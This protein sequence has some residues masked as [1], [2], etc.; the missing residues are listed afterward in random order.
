M[1][2]GRIGE[3]TG[4]AMH[5]KL[6]CPPANVLA[7]LVQ[8]Q[9]VDPQ[10]SELTAHLE[11]CSACQAQVST[12]PP[13]NPLIESLRG[14]APVEDQIARAAPLDRK[15]QADSAAT[16]KRRARRARGHSGRFAR[17]A[18]GRRS[19]SDSTFSR[20][21]NKPDELGRLG[22]YRI[23]KVLGQGGMG[24][25]ADR[26]RGR[27]HQIWTMQLEHSRSLTGSGRS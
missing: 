21:R 27:F 7:E 17:H 23:L 4:I 3:W 20:R 13:S 6:K 1:R 16:F 10:L 15:D 2:S 14:N 19:S 18:V 26:A 11:E 22:R 24:V 9:L 25:W 8:G 5:A 12:V